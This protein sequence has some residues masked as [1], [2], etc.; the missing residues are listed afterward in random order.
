MPAGDAQR[1]WFPE[2]LED[3]IFC[4]VGC[5]HR[6]RPED[7]TL[8]GTAHPTFVAVRSQA[9]IFSDVAVAGASSRSLERMFFPWSA[10]GSPSHEILWFAPPRPVFA[11]SVVR[12]RSARR[13]L[14]QISDAPEP[15]HPRIVR[16]RDGPLY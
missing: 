5:A 9:V 15:P 16:A 6:F 13:L 10:A 1:A 8:V 14:K 3:V 2:M 11:T 4:R 7:G 12:P